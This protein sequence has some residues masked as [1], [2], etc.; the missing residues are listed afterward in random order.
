VAP[1]CRAM[2][3]RASLVV[4]TEGLLHGVWRQR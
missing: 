4:D 2:V 3:F 1:V